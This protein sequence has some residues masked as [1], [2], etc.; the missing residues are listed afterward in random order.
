MSL[1]K[2]YKLN[3][4][5]RSVE[6]VKKDFMDH[7]DTVIDV[8]PE[9]I[10]IAVL[11]YYYTEISVIYVSKVA[12]TLEDD[13][14]LQD[15][16]RFMNSFLAELATTCEIKYYHK[17][18]GKTIIDEPLQD[19]LNNGG[20]SSVPFILEVIENINNSYIEEEDI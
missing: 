2:G 18:T 12:S 7:L 5:L 4:K 6:D 13:K 3:N 1:I 9:A 16:M 10:D 8:Q 14:A 20:K 15:T 19:A 17:E 11:V